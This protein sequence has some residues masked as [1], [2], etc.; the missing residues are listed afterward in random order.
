MIPAAL[1]G[2]DRR[3]ST[4]KTIAALWTLIVAYILLALIFVWPPDSADM[5]TWSTALAKLWPIYVLLLGGPYAAL[6]LAKAGVSTRVNNRTLQKPQGSGD[7]RLSDL[8]GDDSGSPDL[9]DSQYVLFNIIAMIFVVD[10]FIRATLSG[11][12]A[13]PEGLVLLTAGPAAVYTANKLT[14]SNAP[15][16]FSVRPSVVRPGDSFTIYGQNLAPAGAAANG[17]ATVEVGGNSAAKGT[18]TDTAVAATAPT[19]D[20]PSAGALDVGLTTSAGVEALLAS[21]LT[22]DQAPVLDGLN[23]ARA[24][25]G[26]QVDASGRWALAAGAAPTIRVDGLA[27]AVIEQP[28]PGANVTFAV[29]S[30]AAT[31]TAPVTVTVRVLVAGLSSNPA[32]L[33]ITA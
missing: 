5:T 27:A 16:I 19:P 1:L 14:T 10:A 26:S 21:A 13:I 17:T 30:L 32:T 25:V 23:A 33:E 12:P 2:A 3:L 8:M 11:F 7:V 18:W 24:S 20:S 31:A 6:M 4:S 15:V 9:F 22:I 29:P 28:I